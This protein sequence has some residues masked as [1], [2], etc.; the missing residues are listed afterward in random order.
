VLTFRP[1]CPRGKEFVISVGW[2]TGRG[3][4][5]LLVFVGKN[6]SKSVLCEVLMGCIFCKQ[7]LFVYESLRFHLY[8][9]H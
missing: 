8:E 5:M 3:L 4:I 7:L 9:A 6:I 2:E 1:P